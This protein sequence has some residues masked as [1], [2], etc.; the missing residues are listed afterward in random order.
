[1][2]QLV[3]IMAGF[4]VIVALGVGINHIK[5]SPEV[6]SPTS[7]V[8]T[9]KPVKDSEVAVVQARSNYLTAETSHP[10]RSNAQRFTP[11]T[12]ETQAQREFRNAIETL[13]SPESTYEQK[14]AVWKHLKE[15]GELDDAIH[16]FQQRVA[17]NPNSTDDF[18]ALGEAEL[19]KCGQSDDVRETAILAMNAD[20]TF[21]KALSIDPS[22]WE[23]QF[24]KVSAMAHWPPELNQGQKVIDQFQTL[25][26]EQESQPAQ[27]QFAL[28]Y[29]RMGDFYQRTGNAD[30]AAQV[31]QQGAALFPNNTDLQNRLSPNP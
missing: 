3:F 9:S 2:K 29:L 18:V 15:A 27:S 13:L 6:N 24:D 21:D 7:T 10:A 22:N 28:T 23:A 11:F 25:I 30:A 16:E 31:W 5:I 14:Q 26:Q 17:T 4:G 20:Q 1:M 8:M 12:R 19:K